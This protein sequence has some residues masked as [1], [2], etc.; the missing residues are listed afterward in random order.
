[1]S[2]RRPRDKYDLQQDSHGYGSRENYAP[3]TSPWFKY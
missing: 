3:A 1:M 2:G